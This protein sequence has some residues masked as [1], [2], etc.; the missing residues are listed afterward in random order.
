MKA[1]YA[2]CLN[3]MRKLWH[4]PES[5][6]AVDRRKPLT[7][8]ALGVGIV[9]SLE[10]NQRVSAATSAGFSG[11]EHLASS[12]EMAEIER[13]QRREQRASRASSVFN[14]RRRARRKRYSNIADITVVSQSGGGD[15]TARDVRR[16]AG[17]HLRPAPLEPQ[18]SANG[19]I[20]PAPQAADM[21]NIA[22]R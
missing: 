19:R 9:S 18:L 5:P 7:P 17:R 14:Q 21:R 10:S 12:S 15:G 8:A 13:R 6:S 16:L 22:R 20:M 1:S 2:G 3:N 4:R 11:N